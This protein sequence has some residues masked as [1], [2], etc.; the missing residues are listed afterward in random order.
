MRCKQHCYSIVAALKFFLVTRN[1]NIN[2][3]IEMRTDN[4]SVMVGSNNGVYSKL[5]Q[6]N[7]TLILMWCVCHSILLAMSYVSA[8]CLPRNLE[9]L[10]AE[11]HNW[12][13]KSSVRQYKYNELYK[14]IID[15]SQ[16]MK[17]PSGCKT[18]WMS[19][20]PAVENIIAL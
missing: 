10:I 7:P 15:G 18:R 12:F 13:A 2:N 9:Y 16:A 17:F 1:L 20:Q 19:I 6:E 5:K 11:T 8:E 4:A 3:C 14:A